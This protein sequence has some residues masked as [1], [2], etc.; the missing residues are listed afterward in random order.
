MQETLQSA[1]CPSFLDHL[2]NLGPDKLER[3]AEKIKMIN[4]LFSQA[5]QTM[6]KLLRINEKDRKNWHAAAIHG[7]SKFN[8]LIPLTSGE[9]NHLRA[10]N[11]ATVSHLC[12]TNEY[13]QTKIDRQI[14][15]NPRLI[16]KLN[17]LR[18]AL[19]TLN[20]PFRDKRHVEY[21]YTTEK[22]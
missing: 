21:V 17:L 2:E 15:G 20:L 14:I 8:K 16:G 9:A 18:Q 6:A 1:Q 7:H 4:L 5:F 22:L 11:I 12:G 13:G 3:T 19:Y 10:I